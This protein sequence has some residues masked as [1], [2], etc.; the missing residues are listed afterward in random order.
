VT[1]Q[2]GFGKEVEDAIEG[3][4]YGEGRVGAADPLRRGVVDILNDDE[5]TYAPTMPP[6]AMAKI[7]WHGEF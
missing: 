3:L 2:S 1:I 5:D 6:E 4:E 7:R